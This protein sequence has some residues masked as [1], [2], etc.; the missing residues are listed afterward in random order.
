[1]GQCPSQTFNNITPEQFAKLC[2]KAQAAGI[3]LNGNSGTA[4]K[5]GIEVTWN[6]SPDSQQLN[7]Q[8]THVPFFVS[9][10][11]VNTRISNLI[12]QTLSAA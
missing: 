10:N 5:M 11:D 1:M 6:Y 2:E 9:C 4:E 7:I 8:S 3:P 12:S